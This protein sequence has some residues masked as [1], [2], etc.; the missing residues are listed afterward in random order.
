MT[1]HDLHELVS[2]RTG[3]DLETCC[4]KGA[5][6]I[7]KADACFT[8]LRET[9]RLSTEN[10]DNLPFLLDQLTKIANQFPTIKKEEQ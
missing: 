2:A 1:E 10:A 7:S 9:I 3:T 8:Q 6:Y 4:W 5:G